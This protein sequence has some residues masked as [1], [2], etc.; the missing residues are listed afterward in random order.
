MLLSVGMHIAAMFPAYTG[1]PP[2]SVVSTGYELAEYICLTLGWAMAA[3]LVLTRVSVRG[4]VAL[5]AGIAAVE[6]GFLISDLAS[7][8]NASQ[9]SSPGVWLAFAALSLGGAGVLL[10]ASTV[11]MGK[12]C[13]PTSGRFTL[14]RWRPSSWHWWLSP[15]SCRAGT[16]TKWCLPRGGR[17]Q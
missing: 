12:A 15:P 2:A 1:S 7:A 13:G 5:G 14:E 17:R 8:V 16:N 11:P 4:G 6:L 9:G 3:L 10:G